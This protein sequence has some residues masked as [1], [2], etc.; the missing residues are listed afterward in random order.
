MDGAR[1]G[2]TDGMSFRNIKKYPSMTVA[3][4][5]AITNTMPVNTIVRIR[6]LSKQHSIDFLS[7]EISAE[8]VEVQAVE[9]TEEADSSNEFSRPSLVLSVS[10][11]VSTILPGSV[12]AGTSSLLGF[13]RLLLFRTS[14]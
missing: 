5:T 4:A 8:A 2:D 6:Q 3:A 13:V 9:S 12:G 10:G 14:D 11:I 7:L 1:V